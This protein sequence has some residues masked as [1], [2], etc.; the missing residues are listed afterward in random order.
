MT[1]LPV[2]DIATARRRMNDWGR[3]G[4]PFLFI[5]DFEMRQPLVLPLSEVD[6]DSIRYD[7]RGVANIYKG[8]KSLQEPIFE[9]YPMDFTEYR[10]A[11][12]K[13]QYHLHAGDTYLLNLTFPTPIVTNVATHVLFDAANTPYRLWVKDRFVVFSPECF[14]RIENGVIASFPMKGTISALLPGAESQLLNDPKEKAEHATIVDLIRNDLSMVSSEVRVNRF[15]FVD[16]IQTHN[17]PLLQTSSHISGIL[18]SSYAAGIGDLLLQLLPAGSISGAPKQ[19]TVEVI[20]AAEQQDRGYYT[21]VFGIFDGINLDS[22]VM[23]RFIEETP[24]R[25][26]FRSGGGITA[27]SRADAEYQELIQKVYLPIYS[28]CF[29]V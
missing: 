20:R 24:A 2:T 8:E 12:D 28:N 21:G 19:K 4:I 15:R 1:K 11:F 16:T 5:V 9:C 13:V 7:L 14:V 29:A 10:L 25:L 23:I 26:Q 22:A 17:G 3:G 18:P 27:Y 6:P